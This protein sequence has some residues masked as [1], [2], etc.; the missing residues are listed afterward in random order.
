MPFAF[1]LFVP[2]DRPKRIPK[3]CRPGAD[4][5]IVDLDDAVA[6]ARAAFHPTAEDVEWA[7]RALAA[8]DGAALLDRAMVDAPL[9]VRAR[10]V[11]ARAEP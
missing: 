11:L 7:C 9:L 5:V 4:S 1:L 2:A 3:A 6:P 8:G 10:R